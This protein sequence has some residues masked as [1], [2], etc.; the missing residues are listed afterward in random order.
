MSREEDWT[1]L[2]GSD[3]FTLLQQSDKL[4]KNELNR[5]G[6]DF[7]KKMAQNAQRKRVV[8]TGDMISD[9][10]FRTRIID[11]GADSEIEFYMLF[12]TLFVDAGVQGVKDNKNAPDSPYKYKNLGMPEEAI[13]K[14]TAWV[15][16]NKSIVADKSKTRKIRLGLEKKAENPETENVQ[17]INEKEA[18][19]VAYLIKAFGIKKTNII[20]DAWND[21]IKDLPADLQQAVLNKMTF[22]IIGGQ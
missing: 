22:L 13:K 6:T 19:R 17:D 9:N 4:F 5:I 21:T 20:T 3:E 14:L 15:S 16:R 18:R 12:Y 10:N 11:R 7:F 2:G 8:D 1:W